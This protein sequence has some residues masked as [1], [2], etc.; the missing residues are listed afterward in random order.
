M[1][2]TPIS[3]RLA[4]VIKENFKSN[5]AFARFA[6]VDESYTRQMVKGV[7]DLNYTVIR[8]ICLKL[9]YSP[10]WLL[11]GTGNKKYKGSEAKLVT[12]LSMLRTEIDIAMKLNLRLQARITGVE[13]EYEELKGEVALLKA[14]LKK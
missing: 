12:E 1:P 3:R 10:T 13:K 7:H 5:R 4:L 11:F 14:A 6:D 8:A 2:E 9:G